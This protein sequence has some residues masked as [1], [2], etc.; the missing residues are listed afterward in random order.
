MKYSVTSKRLHWRRVFR[1][2]LS[3]PA[4]CLLATTCL[5]VCGVS[6]ASADRHRSQT[7]AAKPA[8]K[9]EADRPRY[10]IDLT[11]DFDHNTYTGSQRVR[12]INQGDHGA[13]V[14][15]FHLYSNVRVD[16]QLQQS[17]PSTAQPSAI[18]TAPDEPRIDVTEVR[19][20]SGNT[21][22]F[23]TLDD[24]G[25]TLRVNLREAV[26]SGGSTELALKF[27]GVVPEIDAEETGL[28]THVVKQVS[29]AVRS[30][31]E[32]RRAREINF[33][34]RGVMFL[35]TA[36]PVLAVHDG[37]DWRRKVEPS[38]G[39][40][41]FAEAS[42]YEAVIHTAREVSVFTSAPEAGQSDGEGTRTFA[43]TALRDF[44][45]IAGR[46]L[47]VEQR[48]SGDVNV[49]SIFLPEHERVGRRVLA[50]AAE[51]V[52]IYQSHFGSVPFTTITVTEAP[53]VAGLGSTEFAGFDVI[54]S[55]FY[56]DF[57][58]PAMR[59]MPELIREQRASLED[60]LEWTV[61]HLVAHQWWGAVVGNDPAREPVLDEAL[62]GWSALLY[63]RE[64]YGEQRAAVAL[65]DQLRGVYRLYRTF[66]GED[67][68]ADH[69]SREYRNSFQ[70][71]AIIMAKGALM[72]AELEKQLG[73][74]R[75]FAA[76]KSYYQANYLEIADMDDLRGAFIAEAP[77]EQRRMVARTF[78]RWLSSKRGDEDIALPD[79]QLA[80]SLGL[81]NRAD[82]QKGGDKNAFT[83]FGKLGKFFWQ[84]MTRIR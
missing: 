50:N 27:K 65:E 24:Q 26:P 12:W 2:R 6:L 58:S 77:I 83:V 7:A 71:A 33:R 82:Q 84:Q 9:I 40:L 61:A 18:E 54:A 53:L 36:F 14:I 51:A 15:F 1:A 5:L 63:Y 66:G 28:V 81:P 74:Q 13:S 29:A 25:T 70:Y 42:D 37:D 78:N 43:G 22:L 47:R 69:P 4:V 39:D 38:I 72:I 19:S 35:G 11:L 68:A 23:F 41:V 45:I 60:S 30:E 21:P 8:A 67:L 52:R 73:E 32:T 34:S 62:A 17:P 59:N 75:F 55:A 46:G 64:M 3:G 79:R 56:V 48:M 10:N 44:A 57:E 80:D 49:R 16:Q 20:V 31:R 76:L